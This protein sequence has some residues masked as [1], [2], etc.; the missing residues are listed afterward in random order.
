MKDTVNKGNCTQ[1]KI[2]ENLF[3]KMI[4]PMEPCVTFCKVFSW[5]TYEIIL[6]FGQNW[7]EINTSFS[8]KG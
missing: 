2:V 4:F 5:K 7:T 8:L 1:Y 6:N 3:K